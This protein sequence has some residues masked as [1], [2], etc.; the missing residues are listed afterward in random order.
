MSDM[1]ISE[2][3][4]K[5]IFEQFTKLRNEIDYTTR[6]YDIAYLVSKFKDDEFF[7]P[8][9]YQRNFVW[10]DERKCRFVESILLGHPIPFMF[11]SK[12]DDGRTEIIDGAQRTSTLVQFLENDL[13]LSDLKLLTELNGSSFLQMPSSLQNRLR[14]EVL[15]VIVLKDGTTL[16]LRQEIFNRINT[17]A[18][19]LKPIETR[20]GTYPGQFMDFI[21]ECTEK[22]LFRK[23]CPVSKDAKKR[24]EGMELVLRFF[25]FSNNY[26]NFVHRVDEFLD[27]YTK[28]HQNS[29]DRVL[30]EKEFDD[31]LSF[32]EEHFEYGFRKSRNA[33]SVPRA[34]FE[35]IS[36]GAILALRTNPAVKPAILTEWS[37]IDIEEGKDFKY[38]T[39]THSSNTKKRV[40]GRIEYVRDMILTGKGKGNV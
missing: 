34:R 35:A 27:E 29:F 40:V 3:R 39:T 7:I 9:E 30:F 17:S 2:Q 25:A 5:T 1:S 10:N 26:D 18:L 24:Y 23:L 8:S 37:N 12:I 33:Q 13:V 16:E 31:M 21:A 20:R 19:E 6:D 4:E 38:H 36:V 22:P 14:D 15:R 32:V 11:F 28:V